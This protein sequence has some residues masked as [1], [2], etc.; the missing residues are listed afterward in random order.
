MKREICI[1]RETP[2]SKRDYDRFGV[3][4][5]QNRGFKI[6][7]LDLTGLINPRYSNEKKIENNMDFKNVIKIKAYRDVFKFFKENPHVFG[8][9]L[10]QYSINNF[11]FFRIMKK[12]NIK[13][14]GYLA[15]YI[16]LLAPVPLVKKS[17]V[18][19]L[20]DIWQSGI[21]NI[22][23]KI[24][25]RF[26]GFIYPPIFI[27]LGGRKS[28]ISYSGRIEFTRPVF[29]HTLDY[30]LYLKHKLSN[31]PKIIEGNYAV[32][33]DEYFP[34]HPDFSLK[35]YLNNPY[36]NY[37][38][39]YEEINSMFD[40]LEKKSGISIVI[41]AHPRSNYEKMAN[42][43]NGRTI[44][45]DKTIDLVADADYV[46][47]H[48]STAVNFAVLFMKP[49]IF[50]M[51][52]KVRGGIFE[53]FILNLSAEFEKPAFDI[54]NLSAINFEKDLFINKTVYERYTVNYI[55]VPGTEEKPFWE[56]VGDEID[57]LNRN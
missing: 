5:L 42:L 48:S 55:K 45:K 14:A 35:G 24:N 33:L 13:Y 11:E 39:Y 6:T 56:V 34:L 36:E 25:F 7:F 50:L 40:V 44:K 10:F 1:F 8:I 32:F 27:L 26:F 53:K 47:A 28:K 43:F 3:D 23:R 38:E 22:L 52:N 31:P 30:D 17:L 57:L 4:L 51:P 2:F 49:L 15:N 37:L 19:R 41:A 9:S 29:I 21:K 16:P 46:L 12:F 54:N 18:S 20:K